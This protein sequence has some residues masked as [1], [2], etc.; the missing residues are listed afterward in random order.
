MVDDS[1]VIDDFNFMR[2]VM[3]PAE[4]DAP[5]VIDADGVVAFAVALEDF[6]TIAGRDG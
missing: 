2:A 3:L 1:E 5:L 6:Q 4:A